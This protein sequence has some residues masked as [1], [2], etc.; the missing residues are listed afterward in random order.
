MRI[1][2]LLILCTF[3]SCM[4]N[5]PLVGVLPGDDDGS[6]QDLSSLALLGLLGGALANATCTPSFLGGAFLGCPLSLSAA[7]TTPYGPAGAST[8][9][10]DTDGNGNAARFTNPFD[11]TS[12]GS[13]LY[14]ADTL[15][16]KIR[17]IDPATGVVTTPFG[18]AAGSSA[19]GDADAT[20]NAAR[21]NVPS[22]I[23]SDET[24][25]YVAD[26]S[27][28]KI[29]RIVIATGAVTTLA[30]P[31]AGSTVSGDADGT[32]NA[33]RFNSPTG[34]ATDGTNLYVSDSAN[35][36]VRQIVIATGVVTTLA[37]PAP[38][39]IIQGH[40]DG[41]GNAARFDTPY[42]IVTDGTNL[43]M[44][45]RAGARIRQI[46]VATAVVTTLAGPAPGALGSGDA[47]GTGNAARFNQPERVTTDG[48]SLYV[49]DSLNHKNRQIGIA[50][51]VLTTLAGQAPGSGPSGTTD[52]TG[53]AARFNR[54]SGI[55]A[56]RTGLYVTDINN[57]KIRRID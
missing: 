31:A 21:F 22:G 36:K 42:G 1:F 4:V 2:S 20:G 19:S 12:D 49:T 29:R 50:T 13:H 11:I 44:V 41:T 14:I 23:T 26:L 24:S 28:N 18:P 40:A 32:G 10:G 5:H 9:S 46:V 54:P 43:Y 52:A 8:T 51:R 3:A 57:R 34:I 47:D 33:A 56:D 45:D 55:I 38:G 7:V 53:N 35:R 25:L 6:D 15:N 17:R 16:N 27:N 30:G 39:S 37:G 48:T